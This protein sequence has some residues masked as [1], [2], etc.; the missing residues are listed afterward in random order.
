MYAVE[1]APAGWAH[2]VGL[3][4]AAGIAFLA[5]ATHQWRM[6]LRD[7]SPPP[8]EGPD[9]DMTPG[10]TGDLTLDDTDDDTLPE[11]RYRMPD[12]SI[13]VR[14]WQP[15]ADIDLDLDDEGEDETREEMADRLVAG[16]GSYADWVRE[17]MGAH[18]VSEATA[19]RAIREA[20][21]RADA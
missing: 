13:L 16:G 3:L 9:T 12:G 4:V 6:S 1:A 19:K 14:R 20:R 8:L 11:G 17:I 18:D 21:D 15:P 5:V 7:P 2:L 10:E